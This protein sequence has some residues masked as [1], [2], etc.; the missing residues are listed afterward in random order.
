[1]FKIWKRL[2]TKSP[3][4]GQ[5]IRGISSFIVHKKKLKAKKT[6]EKVGMSLSLQTRVTMAAI[7][8]KTARK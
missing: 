6:N 8:K 5:R 7:G 2:V 1:M 4:V 3:H